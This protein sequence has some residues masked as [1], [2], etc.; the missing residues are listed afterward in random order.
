MNFSEKNK[1]E[2]QYSIDQD[3]DQVEDDDVACKTSG[4]GK[5]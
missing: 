1:F 5:L 4:L 3:L 2:V